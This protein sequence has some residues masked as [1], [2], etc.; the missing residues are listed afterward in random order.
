MPT[1]PLTLADR[2]ILSIFMRST[3]TYE[4]VTRHLGESGF[5]EQGL[6]LD[7]SLWEDMIDLHWVS[8]NEDLAAERLK[9]HDLFSRLLRADTQR[10]FQEKFDGKAPPKIPVSNEERKELTKLFGRSGSR[11]WTG[12][13]G[14]DRL[15]SVLAYWPTEEEQRDVL[16]WEAWVVKTANE[17][18][19][20][21][22]FSI[23]RIGV[24]APSQP[25]RSAW[26]W[27]CG[28]TSEW[29]THALHAAWWTYS[30]SIGLIVAR[31][32]PAFAQAAADQYAAITLDFLQAGHWQRTGSF[33]ARPQPPSDVS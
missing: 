13:S 5:G 8:L 31:Y 18:L 16:F 19:H 14:S 29:L 2:I 32:T 22:A 15:K 3:R 12:V 4:A 33:E 28:S 20:P 25:S 17:T 9:Q 23:G 1:A 21:S 30:Q 6:M 7:R 24:N 27:R 10:Q 11:S 26:E